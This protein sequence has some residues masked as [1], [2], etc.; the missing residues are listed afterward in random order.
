MFATFTK[1]G[2]YAERLFLTQHTR[3]P[4]PSTVVDE[5]RPSERQT[6]YLSNCYG[7]QKL[8]VRITAKSYALD[9]DARNERAPNAVGCLEFFEEILD[10]AGRLLVVSQARKSLVV[11]AGDVEAASAAVRLLEQHHAS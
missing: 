4:W 10:E 9:N 5:L 8:G 11:P 3:C 7:E 1:I 6:Y 2:V